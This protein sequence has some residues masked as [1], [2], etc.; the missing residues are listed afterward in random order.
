MGDIPE[1]EEAAMAIL[2]PP[3]SCLTLRVFYLRL[4]RCAVDES[5][6]DALT[7][8]LIPLTP[9][10]VLGVSGDKQASI[11]SN[12]KRGVSCPLRPD[13]FDAKAEE[14]TF[15]STATV[16]IVSGSVRFEVQNGDERLL[17]GI[18]ET[19]DVEESLLFGDVKS[20]T[21]RSG[22]GKRRSWVMKCQ[23]A[24]QRGSGFLRCGRETNK[25]P[26]AVEV[27]VAGVVRGTPVVFTKAMQLRFRRRRQVKAFMDTIPEC[28]E[29]PEPEQAEE[30]T[31]R[32][33]HD[34]EVRRIRLTII[35]KSFGSYSSVLKRLNCI[36]C[37][38]I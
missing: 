19:C 37:A 6:L 11:I 32:Q 34:T 15:V 12:D 4:S 5:M 9:D 23:A 20:A 31:A 1:Q 18:L 35:F 10:T 27:Y 21:E 38:G 17:V 25:A 30:T 16:R 33:E 29:L 24:T 14:A 8:S 7:V 22:R 3:S 26:P 36:V 2:E 28:A 13:R